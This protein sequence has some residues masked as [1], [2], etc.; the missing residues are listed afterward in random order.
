MATLDSGTNTRT[1][2]HSAAVDPNDG[3]IYVNG[4]VTQNGATTDVIAR[5]EV[6]ATSSTL[7][8]ALSHSNVTNESHGTSV[9]LDSTGMNLYATGDVDGNTYVTQLTNLTVQPTSVHDVSLPFVDANNNPVPSTGNGVAPDSAGNVDL[10]I[11]IQTSPD[12]QPIVAQVP[13]SFTGQPNWVYSFRSTGPNG[14]MNGVYVDSADNAFFTGGAGLSNPPN[15]DELIAGFSS[16]GTQIGGVSVSFTDNQGNRGQGIGYSVQTDSSGNVF[17]G[18]TDTGPDPSL[19]GNIAFVKLD[20]GFTSILEGPGSPGSGDGTAFG[21]NDDE[22]RG[23]V[24]DP[25][26]GA[27]YIAGYT[28]SP[29]FSNTTGS[30]QPTYGGDPF[31]GVVVAYNVT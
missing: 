2:I 17:T 8:W 4:Q 13:A 21:S 12:T 27:L 1:E 20:S 3:S 6:T 7:D 15:D 14:T 23:L 30:F 11:Q 31:D 24:L 26:H 22:L 16:S 19:G 9:M 18:I 28:N 29:D 10:A 5:I 25:T